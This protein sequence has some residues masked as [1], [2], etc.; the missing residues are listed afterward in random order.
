MRIYYFYSNTHYALK[1][2]TVKKVVPN[3]LVVDDSKAILIVMEAILA[4]LDM[5]ET[6][7][8]C[9]SA[10]KALEKVKRDINYFDAIFTDLNMPEMDGMEL[11]RHLGELNYQG[12][13]IIISEMEHKVISLA[14]N[15]AKQHNAH[16]IG[17]ISKPVQLTQV[18]SLLNKVA[19]LNSHTLIKRTC[20]F[21]NRA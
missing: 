11:I 5:S 14:A 19:Y 21:K 13:I 2:I 16:L 4:E 10:T 7:T 18:G 17:N 8:T 6:I 20:Y 12:A 1:G 3:I 15:L 9:L